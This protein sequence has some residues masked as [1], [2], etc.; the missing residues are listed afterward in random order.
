MKA[1]IKLILKISDTTY[2]KL[3]EKQTRNMNSMV[4]ALILSL[5][6]SVIIPIEI[7]HSITGELELNLVIPSVLVWVTIVLCMDILL[8]RKSV[9]SYFRIGFSLAVISI[10]AIFSIS[11]LLR[12]DINNDFIAESQSK[13]LVLKSNYNTEMEERYI[14][15]HTLV[16]QKIEYHNSICVPEAKNIKAGD[17]YRDKHSHCENQNEVIKALKDKLDA[18]EEIHRDVFN[19]QSN[20]ISTIKS[21]GLFEQVKVTVEYIINDRIYQ[22][23][24]V[25]ILMGLFCIES[26]VFFTSLK[27]KKDPDGLDHILESTAKKQNELNKEYLN[28]NQIIQTTVI[29]SNNKYKAHSMYRNYGD[30]YGEVFDKG[31]YKTAL[32]H[33][34]YYN[35]FLRPAE[36]P[37]KSIMANWNDKLISYNHLIRMDEILKPTKIIFLSSMARQSFHQVFHSKEGNPVT[38]E[39]ISK[40]EVVQHPTSAWWYRASKK[41][42]GRTGRQQL[43]YILKNSK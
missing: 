14:E 36:I 40:I 2:N 34:A 23:F 38:D 35:Y 26:I 17:I 12:K 29:E 3:A 13:L 10:T 41:N 1:L 15:Y 16:N 32:T 39:F 43:S 30:V 42:D 11:A 7:I 22:I 21:L 25:L 28:T 8:L 33:T 24:L 5:I 20:E 37:G 27:L 31:T 18:E 6:I 4:I 19:N 9:P